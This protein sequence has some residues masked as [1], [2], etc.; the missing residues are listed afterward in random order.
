M[1]CHSLLQGSF[2][3]QGLNPCFLHWQVDSLL[4]SPWG[5]P[6]NP[7]DMAKGRSS[8]VTEMTKEGILEHQEGKRNGRNRGQ[9]NRLPFPREFSKSCLMIAIEIVM[10]FDTQDQDV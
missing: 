6:N 3:T 5:S 10:L 2:L 4:L 9:C 8:D 1:G 7:S